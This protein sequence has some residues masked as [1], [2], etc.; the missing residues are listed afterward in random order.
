MAW[1]LSTWKILR[2]SQSQFLFGEFRAK[3]RHSSY[4]KRCAILK[5]KYYIII[6]AFLVSSCSSWKKG[7]VT[8]G[9]KND[10]ILNAILD[11][12]HSEKLLKQDSVFFIYAEDPLYSYKRLYDGKYS[13]QW[14]PDIPY[15][16]IIKVSISGDSE[17]TYIEKKEL[18]EYDRIPS[19]YFIFKEKLF[20]WY[21]ENQP[22]TQELIDALKQFNLLKNDD[23]A[24]LVIDHSKKTA[25]YYF[26]KNNLTQ[27]KRKIS[28]ITSIPRLK[29]LQN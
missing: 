6:L 28:N 10:A 22:L 20:L 15:E 11:F 19:R 13:Y 29:C 5:M 3:T 24:V 21:D 17:N 26:C 7:M 25:Q 18:S 16:N 14:V 23:E 9:N 1:S 8:E 12:T 2:I 27:Y 4:T